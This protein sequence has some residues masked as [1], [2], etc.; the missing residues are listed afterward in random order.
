MGLVP[1]AVSR[2]VEWLSKG[3]VYYPV[4][5]AVMGSVTDAFSNLERGRTQEDEV[6]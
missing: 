6:S 4:A 5:S 1:V 2:L 3:R